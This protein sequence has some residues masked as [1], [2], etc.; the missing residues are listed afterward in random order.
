FFTQISILIER[1]M[2]RISTRLISLS[3]LLTNDLLNYNICS[4]DNIATIP[5]GFDFD[6]ALQPKSLKKV[7]DIPE[8]KVIVAIIGRLAPIKNHD[9]FIDIA[10]TVIKCNPDIQFLIIGDGE[11]RDELQ[12]LI[13][14]KSL[15]K[16]VIITGFF[17]DL[18]EYY[19]EIDISVLTSINEGTPVTILEA[20]FF[21][22]LVVSTN[23]GGVPDLITNGYNGFLFDVK[24][25]DSFVKM[26]LDYADHQDKYQEIMNNA[27]KIVKEKY[28]LQNT[29]DQLLRLYGI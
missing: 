28:S 25:K 15:Q 19:L 7:F 10:E 9:L 12:A 17:E 14:L 8:N 1:C 13:D 11:R 4:E 6:N 26:I 18:N 29:C 27:N 22:V 3:P 20:F 23:V 21:N 2:A 16:S 24:D 5:L